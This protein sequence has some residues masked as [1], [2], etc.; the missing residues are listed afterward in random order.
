MLAFFEKK[1]TLYGSENGASSRKK[2]RNY[3]AKIQPQHK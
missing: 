3:K 1:M 2:M